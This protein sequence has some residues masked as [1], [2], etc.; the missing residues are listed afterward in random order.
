[1]KESGTFVVTGAAAALG[2]TP[3]MLAYGKIRVLHFYSCLMNRIFLC[4]FINVQL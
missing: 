2:P 4:I 1:M 3:D